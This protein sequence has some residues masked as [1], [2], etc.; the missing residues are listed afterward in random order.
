MVNGKTLSEIIP[1]I[2]FTFQFIR[3]LKAG[4]GQTWIKCFSS[5][6]AS[7]S[8]PMEHRNQELQPGL[9]PG[10]TWNK[11]PED[12]SQKYIFQRPYGNHQK[13]EFQQAIQTLGGEGSQ[14]K[15]EASHSLGYS[16]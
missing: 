2:P 9:K 7:R 14:D 11:L 16:R 6:K 8:V 3:Y 5:T 1:T 13:F 10:K 4:A 12:K 15:A